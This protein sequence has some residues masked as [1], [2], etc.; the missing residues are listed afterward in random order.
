[1]KPIDVRIQNYYTQT[2]IGGNPLVMWKYGPGTKKQAAYEVALFQ[3][4]KV[5]GSTEKVASAEQNGIALPCG[6][7]A[8]QSEYQVQVRVWDQ[9]GQGILQ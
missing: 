5:I 3:G 4:D 7:L 6:Q 8:E 1:M 9:E 2:G